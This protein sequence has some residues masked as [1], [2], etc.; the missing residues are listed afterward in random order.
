MAGFRLRWTAKIICSPVIFRRLKDELRSPWKFYAAMALKLIPGL[1]P[2]PI[3]LNLRDGKCFYVKTFMTL[4]IFVEI[5]IERIYDLPDACGTVETIID[6]G[7]NTGLFV[8]R[9]K[10]VWPNATI[11]A[12]EP[13]PE[14]FA[15]LERTIKENAFNGVI[16]RNEAMSAECGVATLFLHPRNVGGHSMYHRHSSKTVSVPARTIEAVLGEM[17]GGARCDLLKIDCEGCEHAIF[18]SLT[19]DTARKIPTIVY[20]P[21]GRL[22]SVRAMNQWLESLGYAT[23][24]HGPL[25]LAHQTF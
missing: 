3:R 15:E 22:Y 13:E 25:I 8:V 17:L 19:V 14:N 18:R 10:Q 24:P 9:A 23:R 12:L 21:E 4:Y 2:G 20:E 5:F 11:V 1:Y 7:A 16:A 6:V